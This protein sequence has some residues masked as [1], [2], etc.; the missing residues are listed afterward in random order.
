[1]QTET[2]HILS[3]WRFRTLLF[4]VLL[5]ALGYLLFMLWAGWDDVIAAVKRVGFFSIV[6]ALSLSLVNYGLRF[7]RWQNFLRLLKTHVPLWESLKIYISGFALTITPAKAG[8]TLRSVFLRDYG[9]SYHASFG[10]FLSERFSDLISM[11]LLA[12]I[13]LWEYP[14]ARLICWVTAGAIFG[15]L[16]ALQ[17][18][19][20]MR[21][22]QKWAIK[23]LHKRIS[24]PIYFFAE[25]FESFG[26][27]FSL[28]ALCFGSFLGVVAWGAEG[29]AFYY[30]LNLLDIQI[31]IASAVFVYA[32]SM[33]IGGISLLPGGLGGAEVTMLQLLIWYN[34][35]SADAVVAT[36]IIRL[37]T[38]WFAV[39]LG[40][41]TLPFFDLKKRA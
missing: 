37:T 20:W 16:I 21:M 31:P 41:S 2:P 12:L 4:V 10:A 9:M 38:L 26:E 34:I 29:V 18:K 30:L 13:G 7:L 11:L 6:V 8:E 15:I 27:C 17:Q 3:G 33:L 32:F 25:I 23:H 1:M 39:I 22:F 36:V 19:V 40:I 35:S 5:S 24:R 14:A 28:K